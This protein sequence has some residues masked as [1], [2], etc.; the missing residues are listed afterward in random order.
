MTCRGRRSLSGRRAAL[1]FFDRTQKL[2]KEAEQ[3]RLLAAVK[4]LARKAER[5]CSTLNIEN[6]DDSEEERAAAPEP[7]P[8][9]EK[10]WGK[11]RDGGAPAEQERALITDSGQKDND[12]SAREEF[13]VSDW[14]S[15]DIGIQIREMRNRDRRLKTALAICAPICV[16]LLI[17][18]VCSLSLLADRTEAAASVTTAEPAAT[19]SP[20]Q[21]ISE[22]PKPVS[23]PKPRKE[24][25]APRPVTTP[26]P[27][28]KPGQAAQSD[29]FHAAD[30]YHP[31]AFYY[32]YYDEFS[33]YEEAEDYWEAH[34]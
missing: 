21:K 20:T 25:A 18:A 24:T 11:P 30:Y 23:T 19:A 12:D 7:Q 33:D 26:R 27:T 4:E 14:D 28:V 10:G 31:D 22:S 9:T 29:P 32:E 16:L 17:G 1:S 13:P 15:S 3:A 6:L 2:R 34:H 8:L 5:D